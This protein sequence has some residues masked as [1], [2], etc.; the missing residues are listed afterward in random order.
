MTDNIPTCNPNDIVV[1]LF[2]KD[3]CHLCEAARDA[4]HTVQHLIPFQF[5]EHRIDEINTLHQE[6]QLKYPVIY[7]NGNEFTYG[8]LDVSAFKMYLL[9]LKGG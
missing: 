7:V 2:S 6:Y 5:F 3:G 4:L 9:H 8:S 1:E